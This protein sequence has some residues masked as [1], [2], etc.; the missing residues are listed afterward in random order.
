MNFVSTTITSRLQHEYSRLFLVTGRDGD[1][2]INELGMVRALVVEVTVPLGWKALSQVWYGVQTDFGLPAP[3]IAVSGTDAIQL[4]FSLAN[5]IDSTTAERFFTALKL[6]YLPGIPPSQLR[7]FPMS[8]ASSVLGEKHTELVPSDRLGTGHWSAFISADLAAI[9][10][11]EPWLDMPPNMDQQADILSKLEP[12]KPDKLLTVLAA[13]DSRTEREVEGTAGPSTDM[14]S[15]SDEMND[16]ESPEI[17]SMSPQ[18]FLL[19]VMRDTR[20]PL[21]HRIEAAKALLPY[22]T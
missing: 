6:R 20:L 8:D 7:L 13:I 11:V 15:A 18:E 21:Q 1:C 22:R 4:W 12:I 10:D 14:G 19:Q 17:A 16:G 3:A 5:D 9:F 2:L